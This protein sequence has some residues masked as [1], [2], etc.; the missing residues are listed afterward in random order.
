MKITNE[1]ISK[2]I[3]FQRSKIKIEVTYLIIRYNAPIILIVIQEEGR[4]IQKNG[5][6]IK[7]YKEKNFDKFSPPSSMGI[8]LHDLERAATSSF[9]PFLVS[10]DTVETNPR[11]TRGSNNRVRS[12]TLAGY[13]DGLAVSRREKRPRRE[14]GKRGKEIKL[15]NIFRAG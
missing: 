3:Q 6:I 13:L 4:K 5:K 12:C 8:S 14:K 15:E 7:I 1:Q 9:Q 2:A 11:T 10:A